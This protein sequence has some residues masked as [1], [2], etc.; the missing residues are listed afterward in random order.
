MSPEEQEVKD[1][2]VRV[3]N[4][5]TLPILQKAFN[6]LAGSKK[7]SVLA[8]S[9]EECLCCSLFKLES[10]EYTVLAELPK[11][12]RD[13]GPTI[14]S[15]YFTPQDGQILWPA[16][17][18]GYDK[19]CMQTSTSQSVNLLF[20]LFHEVRKRAQLTSKLKF[21]DNEND[22]IGGHFSEADICVFLWFC[23]L[24]E[25]N[26]WFPDL[27]AEKNDASI[28]LPEIN[29]LVR[30]AM[31]ICSGS[32]TEELHR[33]N[34]NKTSYTNVEI[35]AASVFSWILATIPGL[36][37]CFPQYVQGVIRRASIS[38]N[39]AVQTSPQKGEV[40]S[41]DVA[42]LLT[43][44]TAW[45]IALTIRA[46]LGGEC[47]MESIM[48]V[49]HSSILPDLIYRSSQHGKGLNRFWSQVEGYNG[50]SLILVSGT[51]TQ[52]GSDQ[53][54]VIGAYTNQGF[55][56]RDS[57]YGSSGALYALK[58]LF[59]SFFPTGRD[60]SFVYSHQRAIGRVYEARPR[61]A[62]IAFGGTQGNERVFI[63]ED[64]ARITIR[65]HAVDK[66]YQPGFLI[67]GQASLTTEASILDVE[68]WGLGGK[69]AEQGQAMYKRREQLFTEQRRKVDLKTFGNW[70]DSPE[71]M[72]MDLMANPNRI[73]REDR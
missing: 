34:S 35:P 57:F 70:E 8:S 68:A 52:D 38:V 14:V 4:S 5:G 66:T 10:E 60:K 31:A 32:D 54:F 61:P 12:L 65:H 51:L 22:K 56:N 50:P 6:N 55:E 25:H 67:P 44:G 46:P 58:P 16:F 18:S 9:L 40:H 36:S 7:D 29:H 27:H 45:A 26:A 73:Q 47:V 15:I 53:R 42:G 21:T 69:I 17:L 43:S 39:V 24:L 28:D 48:S 49:S 33:E 37:H 59:R 3:S 72:M 19:C 13:L 11:L 20:M 62:G 1:L 71:K 41:S 23:W 30:S 64:F 2:E 63:D